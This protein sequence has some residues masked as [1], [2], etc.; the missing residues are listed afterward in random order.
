MKRSVAG[1]LIG[2]LLIVLFAL[3]GCAD[4]PQS[5][6]SVEST[7]PMRVAPLGRTGSGGSLSSLKLNTNTDSLPKSLT[8]YRVVP[9]RIKAADVKARA[10]RLGL[11]G[12]VTEAD[13]KFVVRGKAATLE[14]DRET[15]SFDY[16][17]DNFST[18][19]TALRKTLTDAEYRRKAEVFLEQNGLMHKEAEFRDV[20]R[21]N[22]VGVFENGSWVE[23]PYFIEVRFSHKPLDGVRF[24]QGVGPK[25][26]VQFGD[27]GTVLGAMSIWRDVEPAGRRALVSAREALKEIEQGNAQVFDV[28]GEQ[29]GTVEE[30]MLSYL[31]DPAGYDQRFVVPAYVVKG[32]TASNKR[33]TAITWALG[34]RDLVTDES[35]TG[36]GETSAPASKGP[37]Q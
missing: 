37:K 11:S 17:T 2:P 35:L 21:G 31:N 19:T 22:V 33:F 13:G 20:N 30:V 7:D 3:P 34:A 26:V 18:Q 24:D 1:A 9:A 12:A 8:V 36:S 5:T 16:T 32:K 15:G 14:V 10:Q 4:R 23:R 29:S 25:I 28:Y 6:S 27:D